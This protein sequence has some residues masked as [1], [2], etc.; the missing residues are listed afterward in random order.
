[1][2]E[3]SRDEPSDEVQ[4][5]ELTIAPGENLLGAVTLRDSA[6]PL[7]DLGLEKLRIE[8]E[9]RRQALKARLRAERHRDLLR[10][11]AAGLVVVALFAFVLYGLIWSTKPTEAILA[12]AAPISGFAGAGATYLFAPRRPDS[13]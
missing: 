9:E 8:T 11:A 2:S 3:R 4:L 13:N 1:M 7:V 6:V 12:L 5:G 10:V